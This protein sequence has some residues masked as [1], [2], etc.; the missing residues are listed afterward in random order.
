MFTMFFFFCYAIF[1]VVVYTSFFCYATFLFC[2]HVIY[3]PALFLC[4]IFLCTLYFLCRHSFLFCLHFI[5]MPSY[6][7][8]LHLIFYAIILFCLHCSFFFFCYA[9]F[10]FFFLPFLCLLCHH[11]LASQELNP[12]IYSWGPKPALLS[13]DQGQLRTGKI[14]GISHIEAG[15]PNIFLNPYA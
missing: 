15:V 1:F 6:F 14:Q 7:F 13:A 4:L 9:S 3:M 8:C 5:F 2:L 11:S 12:F 10:L